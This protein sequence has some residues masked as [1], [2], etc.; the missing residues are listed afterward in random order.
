MAHRPPGERTQARRPHAQ[1]RESDHANARRAPATGPWPAGNTPLLPTSRTPS[2]T[3]SSPAKASAAEKRRTRPQPPTSQKRQQGNNLPAPR[4][5]PD[6]PDQLGVRPPTEPSILII[7]PP[8]TSNAPARSVPRVQKRHKVQQPFHND[9]TGDWI[10]CEGPIQYPSRNWILT[11]GARIRVPW[12]RQKELDQGNSAPD[13]PLGDTL[14]LNSAQPIRLLTPEKKANR[15]TKYTEELPPE[16]SQGHPPPRLPKRPPPGKK[17]PGPNLP[18]SRGKGRGLKPPEPRPA[19]AEA[20]VHLLDLN[21]PAIT[22]PKDARAALQE[23]P[24]AQVTEWVLH[25]LTFQEQVLQ[26][27]DAPELTPVYTPDQKAYKCYWHKGTPLYAR[28]GIH[29]NLVHHLSIPGR[30][31]VN[32]VAGDG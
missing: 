28:A 9:H 18:P 30:Q 27:D 5:P 15:G 10:W 13:K 31:S 14:E 17:S 19:P 20:T 2:P 26:C 3:T 21:H 25:L 6:P 4:S 23:P 7:I 29:V 32:E 16:W 1:P 24:M 8:A 12:H 22:Y 11:G